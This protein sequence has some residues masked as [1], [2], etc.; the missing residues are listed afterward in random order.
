MRNPSAAAHVFYPAN[1]GDDGLPAA[2]YTKGHKTRR[3][4]RHF[5]PSNLYF[6]ETRS[7]DRQQVP[8]TPPPS[9]ATHAHPLSPSPAGAD[10]AAVAAPGFHAEA[11][12][13]AASLTAVTGLHAAHCVRRQSKCTGLRSSIGLKQFIIWAH[14]KRDGSGLARA[15]IMTTMMITTTT[16]TTMHELSLLRAKNKNDTPVCPV[17]AHQRKN[18]CCSNIKAVLLPI[19]R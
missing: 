14:G 4:M 19:D 13:R 11:E 6:R 7:T 16:I 3:S 2:W 1:T 12:A 8:L 15:P 5:L 9:M 10:G 17:P 18:D